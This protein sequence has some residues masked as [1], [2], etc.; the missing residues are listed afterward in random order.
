MTKREE[1]HSGHG[2]G[3]HAQI[4]SRRWVS[5]QVTSRLLPPLDGDGDVMGQAAGPP[6]RR[7][8]R[9]PGV[10]PRCRRPPRHGVQRPGA[11]LTILPLPHRSYS[12]L[13]PRPTARAAL[14]VLYVYVFFVC[15]RTERTPYAH[16]SAMQCIFFLFSFFETA[17]N[18]LCMHDASRRCPGRRRNPGGPRVTW[19]VA[20]EGCLVVD[21]E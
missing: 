12:R 18:A 16:A 11:T 20:H 5:R 6:S 3:T 4:G 15:L 10:G 2:T 17:S 9:G 13:L 7:A 8:P 21:D 19:S 1:S 14:Y